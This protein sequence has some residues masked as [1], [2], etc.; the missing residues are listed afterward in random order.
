VTAEPE[1]RM[2]PYETLELDIDG[3]VARL[4][5]MRPEKLNAFDERMSSELVR[6]T[7]RIASDEDV[8]VVVLRGTGDNFMGGADI[9]MLQQWAKLTRDDLRQRLLE[10]FSPSMLEQLPQPVVAAVDGF[11]LGMGCE[12]ALACDLR[13]ITDR[14]RFGLPEIT[15]GLMP[16]AGGSQRLPRL[17]GRTRAAEVVLSGRTLDASEATAYGMA[18][19]CVAADELDAAVDELVASLLSRSPLALRRAKAALRASD[20]RT[21]VEGIEVEFGL[22]VDSVLTEDAHEGT[23]AF[24]EKRRP[25]FVGR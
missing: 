2:A 3:P 8:A 10:G 23:A 7:Q 4:T 11:A 12:V 17:I 15:L 13:I 9:G 21:L 1:Y 5:L 25:T 14:A 24:L 22:F 20:E 6:A 19:R 16:G 18:N